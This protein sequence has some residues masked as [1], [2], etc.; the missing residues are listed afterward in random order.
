MYCLSATAERDGVEYIAVVLHCETSPDRFESAKV[1]LNYAFANYTLSDTS[2]LE[3]SFEIPVKLGKKDAV[4]AAPESC[5]KILIRKNEAAS[6]EYKTE[7]EAL[8]TAP[9]EEG[10]QVGTITVYKNGQVLKTVAVRAG[11]AVERLSAM[12]IFTGF[13]GMMFA[14]AGER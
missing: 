12:N 1:L 8:L 4:T 14:G 7:T 13:L 11:E 3:K 2:E 10:Q 6:L 5:E 9:V